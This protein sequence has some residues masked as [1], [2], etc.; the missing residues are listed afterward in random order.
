[1]LKVLKT[2][3]VLKYK[4]VEIKFDLF[5]ILYNFGNIWIDE[6]FVPIP[7][8]GY[9]HNTYHIIRAKFKK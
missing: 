7:S 4:V 5:S 3:L 9:I 2:L 6:K 1:M 8:I